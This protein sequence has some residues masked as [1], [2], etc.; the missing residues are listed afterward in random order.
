MYHLCW[1]AVDQSKSLTKLKVSGEG[2]YI[3]SQVAR[4]AGDV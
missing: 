2:R 3:V 4:E 1:Q